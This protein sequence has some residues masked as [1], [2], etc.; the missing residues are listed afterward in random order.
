MKDIFIASVSHELRA[1]LAAIL[2]WVELL[3]RRVSDE[4]LVKEGVT[5]IRRNIAAQ[6]R[7][8]D[9]LLD[10]SRVNAGKVAL[11]KAP[12][13]LANPVRAELDELR[14]LAEKMGV[15]V[16]DQLD[17]HA[18]VLGDSTRLRQVFA[19]LLSNALKY[20]P[21]GGNITV[22]LREVDGHAEVLLTDTGA[23]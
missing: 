15:T 7:L 5:V 12:V 21:S 22:K 17:V 13:Q 4:N 16:T 10:L 23:Q 20:T 8:V 6:T 2:A 18:T 1:P 11:K 14:P 19:N 9:D 3:E